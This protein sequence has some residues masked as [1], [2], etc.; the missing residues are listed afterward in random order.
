M[1][2][3]TLPEPDCESYSN[4]KYFVALFIVTKIYIA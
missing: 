1:I 2:R 4:S 3:N